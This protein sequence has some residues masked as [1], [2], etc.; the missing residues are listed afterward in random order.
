MKAMRVGAG[1]ICGAAG[2]LGFSPL[3]LPVVVTEMVDHVVWLPTNSAG[4][5]LRAALAAPGGDHV[6]VT[7]GEQR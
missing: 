7:K 2:I 5:D 1:F 4:C 3:A 6:T